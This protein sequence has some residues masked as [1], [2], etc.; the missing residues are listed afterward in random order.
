[1]I[2]INYRDLQKCLDLPPGK[3][4]LGVRRASVKSP[5]SP[6]WRKVS[7]NKVFNYDKIAYKH[8]HEDYDDDNYPYK[9]YDYNETYYGNMSYYPDPDYNE[10]YHLYHGFNAT[11]NGSKSDD[12]DYDYGETDQ[13]SSHHLVW[14]WLPH[15]DEFK[16]V[17]WFYN[18]PDQP[19]YF[20]CEYN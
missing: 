18:E 14:S 9:D 2:F 13:G 1:M 3:Y 19:A 20:I 12:Q 16:F 10:T 15:D 6:K 5:K 17:N 4:H 7:N 11:F 8:H